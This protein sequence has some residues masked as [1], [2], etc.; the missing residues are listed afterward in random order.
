MKAR[1]ATS[2]LNVVWHDGRLI[3]ELLHSGPIYFRYSPEWLATG[4]NL[5]PLKLA[6]DGRVVN[7]HEAV[8]GVPG[9]ISDALP[10][11]WGRRVAESIFARAGLG[12][13]TPFKLLAWVGT[14]GL[15]AVG[16]EPA[17]GLPEAGPTLIER[18][19]ASALAREAR[20]VQEGDLD[21]LLPNLSHGMTG[22]GAQPKILVV[23]KADNT[24][25]LAGSVIPLAEGEKSCLLKLDVAGQARH[26]VELAY[27]EM[28]AR[29]GIVTPVARLLTD[30]NGRD[31]LLVERFDVGVGGG[32]RH[33]HSLAG[34]LHHSPG[35]LDYAD[36]F[37]TT[38]RLG[39]PRS[40]L[41]SVARRMLF[42]L[43][44]GNQDDHGKNHAFLYDEEF[45][46]WHLAPAYDLTHSPGLDRGLRIAGEVVPRWSRVREWL[47]DAGLRDAE[48][49]EAS[50]AVDDAI[51]A[52]PKIARKHDVPTAQIAEITAT[53]QRITAQSGPPVA[54]VAAR[55]KSKTVTRQKRKR[56]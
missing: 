8:D 2:R 49:K 40:D 3:G 31:H 45:R 9:L 51:A 35:D 14:R 44:A 50:E 30:E 55:A 23:A 20:A 48:I 5:S 41:L 29:A 26:R 52:W 32:K 33:F 34:L 46:S 15:G 53:H 11:A 42:N 37:Q 38:T 7:C 19:R 27:L 22:G 10:D 43:R 13:P 39:C 1:N 21:R 18:V 25:R 6:F 36:F 16:F 54:S 24:L 47:A 17:L 12:R 4:H 28:A 56:E